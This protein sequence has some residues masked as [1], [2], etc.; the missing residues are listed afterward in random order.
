MTAI[1]NGKVVTLRYTVR[2]EEGELLDA[3]EPGEPLVYLHGA[4]NLVPGLE[5]QLDGLAVGAKADAT[6]PPEEAY[7]ERIEAEPEVVPLDS[8]PDDVDVE[9]GLGF[10]VEDEEG[11]LIELFVTAVEGDQ[12]TIDPNHPLAGQALQ[13]A[14]EVLAIREANAEELEHGHP[15]GPEGHG[16]D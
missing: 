12:V 9:P 7:G 14:V 15:H 5:K 4:G 16:H 2:S 1:A 13:F 3:S 6:V 10:A 11:N 8:F